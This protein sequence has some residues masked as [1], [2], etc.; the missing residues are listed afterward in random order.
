MKS[1]QQNFHPGLQPRLQRQQG[2]TLLGLIIGL[3]V[4]LAI[5]VAVA[6]LITKSSTPFTNKAGSKADM[7]T[8]Q[9]LDPNKPL[10]GNKDAA[11]EAA[12]DFAKDP[13]APKAPDAADNKPAV[14]EKPAVASLAVAKPAA[15][16]KPADAAPASPAAAKA[17]SND[18]KYVYFLQAGAFREQADAENARAKLALLGFEARISERASENGNLYRVRIG[19]FSQ[20]ETMNRMRAKLSENSVDVAV[21]RTAK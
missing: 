18:D 17:D 6:L 12:K 21:V 20:V 13:T 14:L 15:E 9:L 19:P 2:G 8:S 7:P 4:G 1:H 16:A 5:A 10:Y 11:K 3:V